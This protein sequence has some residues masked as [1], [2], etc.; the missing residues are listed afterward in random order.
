MLHEACFSSNVAEDAATSLCAGGAATTVGPG[1]AAPCAS[2]ITG[3]D[4]GTA[5]AGIA[6]GFAAGYSGVAPAASLISIQIYSRVA[7]FAFCQG[8]SPCV[9]TYTSDQVAALE[10]SAVDI[11]NF[12]FAARG[13][14]ERT[15]NLHYIFIVKI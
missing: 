10:I 8:H 12:Q 6:A 7:D 2:S 9:G 13:W 14:L 4:H 5:I 11:G 1:T 3:C 15:S